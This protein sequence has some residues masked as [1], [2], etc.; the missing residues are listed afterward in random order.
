MNTILDFKKINKERKE[1]EEREMRMKEKRRER[2][3]EIQKKRRNRIVGLFLV[4]ILLSSVTYGL[5]HKAVASSETTSEIAS[6]KPIEA[7]EKVK[8]KDG[9]KEKKETK[10]EETKTEEKTTKV[11]TSVKPITLDT[12]LY[13]YTDIEL[14][15]IEEYLKGK[16]ALEG[17][18]EYFG[19]TYEISGLAPAL[20]VA[21]AMHETGK[22]TS[23]IAKEFNNLGGMLCNSK[24]GQRIYAGCGKMPN[25]TTQ[26][27]KYHD[28]GESIRHKARLLTNDFIKDGRT[29]IG[30]IWERYAPIGAD[31]DPNGVNA[32]WGH[33]VL[34]YF[35]EMVELQNKLNQKQ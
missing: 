14:T 5:I 13:E 20:F 15:T 35:N 6:K 3:K 18:A 34:K 31:N 17:K 9:A 12:D 7:K 8:V 28:G 26:W 4:I 19:Q 16:G 22:G 2:K 11:N 24:A 25:G 10:Q 32:A 33:G 23:Y 29:S 30:S 21:I 1:Q 27:Q